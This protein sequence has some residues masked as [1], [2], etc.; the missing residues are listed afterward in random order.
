MYN[1]ASSSANRLLLHMAKVN[2]CYISASN[3]TRAATHFKH[4]QVWQAAL[5]SAAVCSPAQSPGTAGAALQVLFVERKYGT[6]GTN[7]RDQN[8]SQR[9]AVRATKEGART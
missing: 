2:E 4:F 1:F 5:L 6:Q 7:G 8:S 9:N 3:R